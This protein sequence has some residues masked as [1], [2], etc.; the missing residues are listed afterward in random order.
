MERE[1]LEIRKQDVH[2]ERR[3]NLRSFH[4]LQVAL[5]F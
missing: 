4:S 3:T 2:N 5:D 1:F